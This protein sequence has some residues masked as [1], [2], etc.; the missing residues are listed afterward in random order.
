[1]RF[2]SRHRLNGADAAEYAACDEQRIEELV[3]TGACSTLYEK[4]FV[5]PDGSRI[6]VLVGG[7]FSPREPEWMSF[8]IDLTDRN[9]PRRNWRRRTTPLRQSNEELQQFAYGVSHD[10]QEPLRTITVYPVAGSK[11]WKAGSWTT[12]HGSISPI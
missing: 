4:E 11:K 10:L 1:M 7:R 9:A 3:D 2:S 5:R 6:P 8:V 12:I